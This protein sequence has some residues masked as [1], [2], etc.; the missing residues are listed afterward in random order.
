MAK[1]YKVTTYFVDYQEMYEDKT[2]FINNL[3]DIIEPMDTIFHYVDLKE[4]DEFEWHD[5]NKLNFHDADTEDY[6]SYMP[7]NEEGDAQ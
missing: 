3:E 5:S 2:D 1:V 4:S 7:K 6:E